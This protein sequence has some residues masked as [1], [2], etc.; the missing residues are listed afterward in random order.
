MFFELAQALARRTLMETAGERELEPR[1]T[2]MFRLC[3]TRMPA[4]VEVQLLGDYWRSEQKRYGADEDAAGKLAP[5]DC[6]AIV[7]RCESPLNASMFARTQRSAS[8]MS[9]RP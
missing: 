3:L 2:R 1:L 6:P 7:T 5:A 8:I 4:P 9:C